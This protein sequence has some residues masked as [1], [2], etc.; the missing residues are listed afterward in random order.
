[1]I[2]Q[3][4]FYS[5][6]RFTNWP[7]SI[8]KEIEELETV[9]LSLDE[10][11]DAFKIC[12]NKVVA[13]RLSYSAQRIY[14]IRENIRMAMSDKCGDDMRI[15]TESSSNMIKAALAGINIGSKSAKKK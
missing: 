7:D 9:E 11:S 4:H 1:M 2:M 5:G 6:S 3:K 12:G 13:D 8:N 14:V 10:L 15:I